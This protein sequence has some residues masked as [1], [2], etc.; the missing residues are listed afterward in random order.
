MLAN[1]KNQYALYLI[2]KGDTT[3]VVGRNELE[4]EALPG[5]G[6]VKMEN[7]YTFQTALPVDGETE[8]ER[9]RGFARIMEGITDQWTG[10]KP[11]PIPMMPD[12][13]EANDFY[14]LDDVSAILEAEDMLFPI[15]LDN[16]NVEPFAVDFTRVS[17]MLVVGG[18]Q[19]GKSNFLKVLIESAARKQRESK[20]YI[21]DNDM[22]KLNAY[23]GHPLTHA[24][25]MT[26]QEIEAMLDELIQEVEIRRAAYVDELQCGANMTP[27]QFYNRYDTRYVLVNNVAQ[28]VGKVSATYQPKAAQLLD[29]AKQTGIH[30][31]FCSNAG[32]Y[33]KGFDA[34]T[35]AIKAIETGVLLVPT[36]QQQVWTF[37]YKAAKGKPMD[38][39]D[40]FFVQGGALER[41]KV[42]LVI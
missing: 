32:D 42:P 35:K 26:A 40:A 17:H 27:Q 39:G 21:V 4:P 23:R 13:V 9:V 29:D 22:V 33:A 8:E 31:I 5:R 7:V 19:R 18:S 15:G 14:G 36:D 6:L 28:F 12:A 10:A 34:Y 20:F 30:F 2:D 24:Y 16:E 25:V 11:A 41:I 37:N 3:N 1:I 38:I